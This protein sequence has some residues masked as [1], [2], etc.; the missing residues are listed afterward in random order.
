MTKDIYGPDADFVIPRDRV[1]NLIKELSRL[2]AEV[3]KLDD[4][5]ATAERPGRYSELRGALWHLRGIAE[6]CQKWGFA[7]VGYGD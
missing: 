2:L 3:E 1:P 6:N 7:I 5:W 4:P